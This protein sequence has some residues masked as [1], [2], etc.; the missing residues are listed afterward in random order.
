MNSKNRIQAA[1][2]DAIRHLVDGLIKI[3]RSPELIKFEVK[4]MKHLYESGFTLENYEPFI[5]YQR[6]F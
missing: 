1:R 2:N 6:A 3:N 5:K 4:A